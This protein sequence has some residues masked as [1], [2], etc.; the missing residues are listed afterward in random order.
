[1]ANMEA[2]GSTQHC[3]HNKSLSDSYWPEGSCGAVKPP[4]WLSV[5]DR[6]AA[7]ILLFYLFLFL[8]SVVESKVVGIWVGSYLPTEAEQ[9]F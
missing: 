6:L 1:M 7:S 9:P 4:P 3:P 5:T 2:S 8:A